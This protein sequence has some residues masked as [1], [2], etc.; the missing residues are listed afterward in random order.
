MVEYI[1]LEG[2]TKLR[3]SPSGGGRHS[4]VHAEPTTTRTMLV[5]HALKLHARRKTKL[6]WKG[7]RSTLLVLIIVRVVCIHY[8]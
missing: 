6:G 7:R 4:H 5:G 8:Y 2:G 1:E 3:P